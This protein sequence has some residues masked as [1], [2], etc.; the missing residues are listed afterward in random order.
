MYNLEDTRGFSYPVLSSITCQPVSEAHK[1]HGGS[2]SKPASGL[3]EH[4]SPFSSLI[5]G[6]FT[7]SSIHYL[8][9]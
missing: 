4:Y 3:R 6:R 2:V 1:A 9:G 7:E 8:P 5:L